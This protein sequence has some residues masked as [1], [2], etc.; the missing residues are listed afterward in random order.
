VSCPLRCRKVSSDTESP[1]F[2][3]EHL[4]IRFYSD[5]FL[6]LL[7]HSSLLWSSVVMVLDDI[8]SSPIV[9]RIIR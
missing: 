2:N 1:D 9:T 4:M 3:N 8:T 7:N 5:L 6:M